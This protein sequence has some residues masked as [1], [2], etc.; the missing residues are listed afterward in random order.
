MMHVCMHAC[1]RSHARHMP[2]LR[3]F[4]S[5]LAKFHR[6]ADAA[7]SHGVCV[8]SLSGRKASFESPQPRLRDSSKDQMRASLNSRAL[9]WLE[10]FPFFF[11]FMS[12]MQSSKTDA[13]MAQQRRSFRVISSNASFPCLVVAFLSVW[14]AWASREG[15][16]SSSHD[17]QC[18]ILRCKS[19]TVSALRSRF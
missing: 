14:A 7:S 13:S 12:L 19:D 2:S 17:A 5:L 3:A 9:P 16:S 4:A 6:C 11:V 10:W 1:A 8:C 18:P 15:W